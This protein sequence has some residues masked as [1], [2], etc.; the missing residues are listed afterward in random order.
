MSRCRGCPI[1]ADWR[2]GGCN[3]KGIESTRRNRELV[4]DLL[5]IARHQMLHAETLGFVHPVTGEEMEFQAAPPLE[6]RL[7]QKRLRA[8]MDE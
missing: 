1:V 2:Y 5:R 4:S 8:D 6:F 7:V 3:P